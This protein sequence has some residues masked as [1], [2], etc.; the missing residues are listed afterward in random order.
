MKMGGWVDISTKNICYH[1]LK[2]IL[3]KIKIIVEAMCIKTSEVFG[4]A[5]RRGTKSMV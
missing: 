1:R 5:G 2:S 3:S 4:V